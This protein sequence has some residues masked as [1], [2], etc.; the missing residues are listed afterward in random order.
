MKRKEGGKLRTWGFTE[1]FCGLDRLVLARNVKGRSP[2]LEDPE[3][4][5]FSVNV[6]FPQGQRDRWA[7]V[8]EEQEK[9]R[10]GQDGMLLRKGGN[11]GG[12]SRT[13]T[14]LKG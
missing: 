9:R 14:V 7:A 10:E 3:R 1:E 5:V 6:N 12:P 2:M 8:V 4:E 13:S 11:V